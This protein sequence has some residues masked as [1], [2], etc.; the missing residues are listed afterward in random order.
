MKKIITIYSLIILMG[1]S[2]KDD[3]SD[4]GPKAEKQ[5]VSKSFDRAENSTH[6]EIKA[7]WW[8]PPKD[9]DG[10]EPANIIIHFINLIH[11][12]QYDDAKSLWIIKGDYS[13]GET[14]DFVAYC[15]EMKYLK[16]SDIDAMYRGKS[17][18]WHVYFKSKKYYSLKLV[19]GKWMINRGSAW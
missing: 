14:G 9:V 18:W 2:S 5:E 8:T 11:E 16:V 4:A 10:N 12:E 6:P 3:S 7:K 1:C 17:G 19:N 13:Y 15:N